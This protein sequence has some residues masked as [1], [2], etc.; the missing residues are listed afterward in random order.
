VNEARL[1]AVEAWIGESRRWL[2]DGLRLG[3]IDVAKANR[4]MCAADKLL[5]RIERG[6]E[7][8]SQ[9]LI[10][11]QLAGSRKPPRLSPPMKRGAP[12]EEHIGAPEGSC[13]LQGSGT[14]SPYGIRSWTR[15]M[16]AAS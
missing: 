1:D 15:R 9:Y 14:N 8:I 6:R 11:P 16:T 2:L 12:P 7:R 5:Y 4:A 3:R 13:S 10:S